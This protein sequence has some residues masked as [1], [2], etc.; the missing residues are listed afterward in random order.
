MK[1]F[2]EKTVE[3]LDSN[4][5]HEQINHIACLIQE[6]ID[7]KCLLITNDFQFVITPDF[8]NHCFYNIDY[9]KDN[10]TIISVAISTILFFTEQ[11]VEKALISLDD[12]KIDRKEHIIKN[13]LKDLSS[14]LNLLRKF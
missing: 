7:N 4:Y 11:S 2:I 13:V 8:I 14:L 12:P 6:M 5:S 3:R 1:T 9:K 10:M